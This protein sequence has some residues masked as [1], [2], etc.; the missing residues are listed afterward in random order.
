VSTSSEP[1]SVSRPSFLGL[2]ISGEAG[3]LV[4]AWALARWL[5]VSPLQRLGPV[6][7]GLLWGIV[8]TIP[9]L[10]GLAWLLR[11]T[12][13]PIRQLVNLVVEQIGPYLAPLSLPK[14]G[15]VALMAGIS[16][17]ILFRGVIQM[18]LA[19]LMYPTAALLV[20]GLLFGLV[21]FASPS[22]VLFAAVMGWY[23]GALFLVQHSLLAPIVTHCLYDFVALIAVARRARTL[24]I[25]QR[26]TPAGWT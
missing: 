3:L 20:T 8:G 24:P 22:Y 17:E 25:P 2:A 5:D 10:L 6:L 12:S 7:P 9:P 19:Q 18:G 21:H 16:E 23:L 11:S 1:S 4:L 14:L 15:A 26:L 13:H